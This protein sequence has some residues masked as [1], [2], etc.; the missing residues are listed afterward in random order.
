MYLEI[1][2]ALENSFISAGLGSS[3]LSFRL[4]PETDWL[5]Y[6]M[7]LSGYKTAHLLPIKSLDLCFVINLRIKQ[8][9]TYLT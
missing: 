2:A 5:S 3:G 1:R 4:I 9:L 7:C 8:C 6:N